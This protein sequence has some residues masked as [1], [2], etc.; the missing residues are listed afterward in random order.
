MWVSS[1][2]FYSFQNSIMLGSMIMT[3]KMKGG[4]GDTPIFEGMLCKDL[5]TPF[6]AHS[7]ESSPKNP[8]F[9]SPPPFLIKKI[10][11]TNYASP[12]NPMFWW[13]L[14]DFPLNF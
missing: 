9:P 5:K 14:L 13:F 2:H 8:S 12:Q 11:I 3:E 4:G 1:Q 10:K 6:S 7:S